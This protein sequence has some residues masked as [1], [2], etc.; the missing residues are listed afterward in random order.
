MPYDYRDDIGRGDV[1]FE[2]WGDTEENLLYAAVDA[3]VE[4]MIDSLDTLD[5]ATDVHVD[6]EDESFEMLLM[7]LLQEIIYYK[8]AE[9]LLLRITHVSVTRNG[10]H[11]ALSCDLAGEKINLDKHHMKTD[12]KAVTMH[13]FS[14]RQE[15]GK[16]KATVILDV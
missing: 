8:D 6:L 14:V 3:T 12:V 1:A 11:V 9:S 10:E 13:C 4:A 5:T 7:Q 2:A 16:W 15:N